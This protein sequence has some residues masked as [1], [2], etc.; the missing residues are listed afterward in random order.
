MTHRPNWTD[1]ARDVVTAL[2]GEPTS[3]HRREWYWGTR[4]SLVLY[5][6]TGSLEDFETGE[7]LDLLGFIL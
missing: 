2:C 6:D 3:R 7:E 1:L 5:L 4:G